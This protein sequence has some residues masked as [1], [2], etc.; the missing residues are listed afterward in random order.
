MVTWIF[1]SPN[2]TWISWTFLPGIMRKDGL[3]PHIGL[4]KSI[5]S[6]TWTWPRLSL[7]GLPLLVM[8]WIFKG[9]K[10]LSMVGWFRSSRKMAPANTMSSFH[11]KARSSTCWE[12][13]GQLIGTPLSL[14][15]MRNEAW[16]ISL[17]LNKHIDFFNELKFLLTSFSIPDSWPFWLNLLPV[18][19]YLF[20]MKCSQKMAP[21]FGFLCDEAHWIFIVLEKVGTEWRAEIFDSIHE[22]PTEGV[23]R[24]LHIFALTLGLD[25]IP[26]QMCSSIRQE[27]GHHCGAIC[28]LE[29]GKYL[30]VFS[31]I[32]DTTA[33]LWHLQLYQLQRF[34]GGGGNADDSVI[35]WLMDF[36][37][38]KGVDPAQTQSR[39]Q[40]ALRQLGRTALE[41]AISAPDPWR[42]LKQLGNSKSKPFLWVTYQE[43]QAHITS[44]AKTKHGSQ[45]QKERKKTKPRNAEIDLQLTPDSLRIAENMFFDSDEKDVHELPFQ[46][47]QSDARGIAVCLPEQAAT[48]AKEDKN[49]SV[50]ALA[51]L[52]IGSLGDTSQWNCKVTH[53]QWPAI[54]TPSGDPMLIGGSLVQLG[55]QEVE[56]KECETPPEVGNIVTSTVRLQLF[57]DM[58]EIPWQD[59]LDGPVKALTQHIMPLQFCDGGIC[60]GQ[61]PRYH[62]PVDEDVD[63]VLIDVFAWRWLQDDGKQVP[64]TKANLFSV[65][66]R[67]PTSALNAILSESGWNGFFAEPRASQGTGPHTGYRVV[68]LPKVSIDTAQ[69]MKRTRSDP[70]TGTTQRQDWAP[71]Q[72]ERRGH[73][74]Q[75]CF[76]RPP[77]GQVQHWMSLWSWTFSIWDQQDQYGKSTSAVEMACKSPC[78]GWKILDC[79]NKCGS[80]W[81][82][83]A[84]WCRHRHG[85]QDQGYSA[86]TIII[87]I[88][89]CLYEDQGEDSAV[90]D[91]AGSELSL[92]LWY[93][94]MDAERPLEQLQAYHQ[95]SEGDLQSGGCWSFSEADLCAW[96]THQE[97][98]DWQDQT[99]WSSSGTWSNQ[100]A[101]DRHCWDSG[102][103]SAVQAMVPRSGTTSWEPWAASSLTRSPIGTDFSCGSSQFSVHRAASQWSGWSSNAGAYCY[104]RWTAFCNGNWAQPDWSAIV[105]AP[106][107]TRM[108]IWATLS[109]WECAPL[110]FI[111]LATMVF[112]LLDWLSLWGSEAPRSCRSWS[113]TS[114]YW[115]RC[116]YCQPLWATSQSSMR[117]WTTRWTLAFQWNSA[118]QPRCSSIQ[119]SALLLRQQ[120]GEECAMSLWTSGSISFCYFFGWGLVRGYDHFI[121]AATR[122][123][124]P[125][126][127]CRIPWFASGCW[128][129]VHWV[130]SDHIRISLWCSKIAYSS[131]TV[132]DHGGHPSYTYRRDRWRSAGYADYCWWH[133]LWPLWS[134]LGTSLAWAWLAWNSTLWTNSMGHSAEIHLQKQ[135]ISGLHL[136]ISWMFAFSHVSSCWGS[137][138]S[139]SCSGVWEPS[140]AMQHSHT[141][142][143][144][145]TCW[146]TLEWSCGSWL[147][148]C[149][150][151][152][153]CPNTLEQ[154]SF[155]AVCFM[156]P[157]S[158]TVTSGLSKA[159]LSTNRI[160]HAG[161][162]TRKSSTKRSAT[163]ATH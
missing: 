95:R 84:N 89:H 15:S 139:W 7:Y 52:T 26:H 79:R 37:P 110:S 155:R 144:A 159:D 22:G 85:D 146:T 60:H 9:Q 25:Q 103:T 11:Q 8:S 123:T 1:C 42:A 114:V 156:E 128:H 130:T 107:D 21:Y 97:R 119:V 158:G 91:K 149:R 55:D 77:H 137:S 27:H 41:E 86:S 109:F 5:A 64:K 140:L 101:A 34:H 17:W 151:S 65:Y 18:K 112:G 133:E 93:W 75:T 67:V 143:L 58:T 148:P 115:F 127:R 104:P 100:Y 44:K 50:D 105:Q 125:L 150:F 32:D 35:A 51:L 69:N 122:S 126:A 108:T 24:L 68:W 39:A 45:A 88:N 14:R 124:S 54:Y 43:L 71:S 57:A 152:S 131:E 48:L 94:S 76:P 154:W 116:G 81:P 40:S 163:T 12:V 147:A 73:G 30:G 145:P 31:Q 59:V 142:I 113:I 160:S 49:L 61:C 13:V 136:V 98:P 120:K 121:H 106:Q 33:Q 141:L 83:P 80:T 78:S 99:S 72:R 135:H 87:H 53:L 102:P 4:L 96:R 2:G 138:F 19:Q 82:T 118:V 63:Y 134:I 46:K 10:P 132:A 90:A 74:T 157:C 129:F 161:S 153:T 70:W 20:F 6:R 28:L 92:F 36:L 38:A 162:R 16:M 56:F 47:V 66:V 3:L 111:L 23:L 62:A 29:L 117:W